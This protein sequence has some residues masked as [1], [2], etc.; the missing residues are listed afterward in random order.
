MSESSIDPFALTDMEIN[1]FYE[2]IQKRL[3]IISSKRTTTELHKL[4]SPLMQEHNF[5]TARE[6]IQFLVQHPHS[7]EE[8]QTLIQAVTIG[9]SYFCREQQDFEVIFTDL[10][11]TLKKLQFLN[12]WSLGCSTGEEAYTFAIYL[13][14]NETLKNLPTNIIGSDINYKFI[15]RAQL[16]I[17]R[18][19]ALRVTPDKIKEKY[20]QAR[21]QTLLSSSK[22]Q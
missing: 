14:E 1:R 6:C 13:K 15:E 7:Q 12:M 5:K 10:L 17:Y 4:L 20:F 2:F 9:E 11:P 22:T 8:I 18:D 19:W 3:G 21:I 16:G